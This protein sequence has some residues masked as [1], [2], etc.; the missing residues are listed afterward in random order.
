TVRHVDG[1]GIMVQMKRRVKSNTV[2]TGNLVMDPDGTAPGQ[3][4]FAQEGL[5][6]GTDPGT[7]CLAVT[8]GGTVVP[9]SYP[10]QLPNAKNQT[11]G[12]WDPSPGSLG[13]ELFVWRK[14]GTLN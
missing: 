12:S 5:G 10:S 2:I 9:A 8:I 13:D 7:G 14:T 3:A 11:Q 4:I 1:G 6:G